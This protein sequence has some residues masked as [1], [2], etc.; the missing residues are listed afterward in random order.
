[1]NLAVNFV[2]ANPTRD[3]L[4]VLRAEVQDQN[5]LSFYTDN[6]RGATLTGFTTPNIRVFETTNP[7]DTVEVTN[8]RIQPNGPQYNVVLPPYRG[9]VIYAVHGDTKLF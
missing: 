2:L 7:G 9:A 6:Y 1:M 3:E 8:L 4:R 5:Q